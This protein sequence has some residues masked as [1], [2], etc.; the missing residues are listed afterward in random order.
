MTT[1]AVDMAIGDAG[2][3]EP[4]APR[5]RV[6]DPVWLASQ[7][8]IVRTD[9]LAR[10]MGNAVAT[11][12][13]EALSLDRAV[14]TAIDSSVSE[15]ID[16]AAITD[17]KH[18]GRCWAFAGL[19]MIRA[20]IIAELNLGEFELSQNFV[21]FHDMVEKANTFLDRTIR[22]AGRPLDD[23]EVLD[24]LEHPI[25]D[26]GYWPEFAALVRK[27]GL[28]PLWAM[29][30]TDSATDTTA[31][32]EHVSTL[33]RRAAL[34][35][36]AAV[37]AGEDPEPL[38]C[39]A[40]ADA[41]RMLTIHLG[42]PPTE[43]M[44]QY[45]DKDKHFVREGVMTPKEFGERHAGGVD[46]FVVVCHDP[47]PDIDVN[48][49][50]RVDRSSRM[51]GGADQQHVTADLGVLKQA[52]VEAIQDGEP[53]WFACDVAKQRDKVA[54]LWHAHLHDYEDVYG[55][56]LDL[57]K[58]DRLILRE[59]TLSH[60]MCFTGVDLVDGRP[61][62]WRVQNSWGD[63]MGEKGYWTMDDSWFDEYV[64][65]VVVRASRLPG[66]VRAGLD[67]EPRVL[68]SWDPMA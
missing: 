23:R 36:R 7:G 19:N 43:F 34:R 16:D 24:E 33:L 67:G 40:L 57:P 58:A 62:R 37:A 52:S 10:T 22:D 64:F 44:W 26:G 53:V 13:V 60:A 47:R 39:Q 8:Q 54:G 45:R 32:D 31:M 42:T 63:K 55:V 35:I 59:T 56:R 29:P 51:V 3:S 49:T 21:F 20:R 15:R 65:Q 25:G 12:G 5:S 66:A 2:N 28:V 61:R 17:Q 9:H 41:H 11:T 68:P 14:V 46:E 48:T 18:S 1:R 50:Y 38:R 27:Y 6:L 4:P 30:D